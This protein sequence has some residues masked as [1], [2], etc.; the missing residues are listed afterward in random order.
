MAFKSCSFFSLF[1]WLLFF[2]F[3]FFLCRLLLLRGGSFSV[4]AL[5][6]LNAG[7]LHT[8]S[9]RHGDKQHR[10]FIVIESKH[11]NCV[12]RPFFLVASYHVQDRRSCQNG[13]LLRRLH[14]R[15]IKFQRRFSQTEPTCPYWLFESTAISQGSVPSVLLHSHVALH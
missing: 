9:C 6:L 2:C 7:V 5:W 1:Y 4:S 14:S 11:R 12:S 8:S 10:P 15:E 13:R 3:V